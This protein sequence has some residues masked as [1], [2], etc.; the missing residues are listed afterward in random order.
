MRRVAAE[1]VEEALRM[2]AELDREAQAAGRLGQVNHPDFEW[3]EL[4]RSGSAPEPELVLLY[5]STGARIGH[6]SYSAH[7]EPEPW[8][9]YAYRWPGGRIAGGYVGGGTVAERG[10]AQA[11]LLRHAVELLGEVPT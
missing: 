9:A 5:R 6:V 2:M 4:A 8:D 7:Y 1:H 3:R 11:K 10:T